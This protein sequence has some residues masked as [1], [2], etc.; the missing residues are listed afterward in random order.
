M[1][2]IIIFGFCAII[3]F[4]CVVVAENL[5]QR[6]IYATLCVILWVV[7]VAFVIFEGVMVGEK[8]LASQTCVST[9]TSEESW[10]AMSTADLLAAAEEATASQPVTVVLPEEVTST[11]FAELQELA[12]PSSSSN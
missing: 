11:C 5:K 8:T 12:Q 1:Y 2:P 9:V 7:C 10:A 6:L 3:M 4:I